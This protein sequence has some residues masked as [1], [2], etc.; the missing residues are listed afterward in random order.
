MALGTNLYVN[1][2]LGRACHEFI[3]AVTGNFCLVV[4]RMD[5]FFHVF[6]LSNSFYSI[7]AAA[8]AYIPPVLSFKQLV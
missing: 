5:T 8:K 2:L 4:R 7:K 6:H 3:A 1:L